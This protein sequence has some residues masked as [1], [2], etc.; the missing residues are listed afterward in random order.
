[1]A[2]PPPPRN[3]R[4]WNAT[5]EYR[6][7]QY[8]ASL[9]GLNTSR[10]ERKP[11]RAALKEA[12]VS[13]KVGMRNV[14]VAT[15]RD[16]FGRVVANRADRLF[17]PMEIPTPEGRVM[18]GVYG[19]RVAS[20]LGGYEGALDRFLD[21]GDPRVLEPWRGQRVAGVSLT[22]DPDVVERMARDGTLEEL[23]PYPTGG[24]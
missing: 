14:G 3:L 6:Q 8:L 13:Y 10:T 18:R 22:T 11:M 23:E 12:G 7:D 5:S 9:E 16:A 24:R 17:R 15:H 21:T 1:M 2:I 19:S 20:R 4:Q